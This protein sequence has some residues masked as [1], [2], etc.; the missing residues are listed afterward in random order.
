M[1]CHVEW[2]NGI[3]LAEMVKVYSSMTSMTIQNR[4]VIPPYS[5]CH[6]ITA[7]IRLHC[8]SRAARAE[9]FGEAPTR[10]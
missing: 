9:G 8:C 2:Y 1:R 3:T 7:E 6:S 10:V 4:Q 5:P